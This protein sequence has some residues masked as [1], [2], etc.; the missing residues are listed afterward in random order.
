MKKTITTIYFNSVEL[1]V[2][3][4]FTPEFGDEPRTFHDIGRIFVENTDIRPL[5]TDE[6]EDQINQILIDKLCNDY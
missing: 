6:Q 2:E 1:D 4:Y 5:L 3:F